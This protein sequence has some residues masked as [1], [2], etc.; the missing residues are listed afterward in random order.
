MPASS[1]GGKGITHLGSNNCAMV[2]PATPQHLGE[3]GLTPNHP[4]CFPWH[5]TRSLAC[6]WLCHPLIMA[7][8]KLLTLSEPLQTTP[9]LVRGSDAER[10]FGMPWVVSLT[11]QGWSFSRTGLRHILAVP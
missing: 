11:P 1:E 7:L 5:S 10:A 4:H 6:T 8:E 9:R 3:R 2:L